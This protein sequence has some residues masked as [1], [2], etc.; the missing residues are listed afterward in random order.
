MQA[1]EVGDLL[2]SQAGIVDQP[3][4]GGF[5]HQRSVHRELLAL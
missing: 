5:G 3:H 2:E 1:A 4:G